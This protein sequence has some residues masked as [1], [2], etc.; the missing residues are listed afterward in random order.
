MVTSSKILTVSYGTF[1]CTLE[2]FDDPFTTLQQVA[3]Y[4]RKLAAADRYFGGTPQTPSTEMLKEIAARNSQ[5]EVDAMT[6]ENGVVLR[7]T[8][9]PA[10][11]KVSEP[12]ADPVAAEKAA[13][14]TMTV[15]KTRQPEVE[16]AETEPQ[17]VVTAPATPVTNVAETLAAIRHNVEQAETEIAGQDR[18]PHETPDLAAEFMAG[19]MPPEENLPDD[20]L[21]EADFADAETD[22]KQAVA[23]QIAE[24]VKDISAAELP[25]L[26]TSGLRVFDITA[27]PADDAAD[28]PAGA[29]ED[30]RDWVY[31]DAG[32]DPM[33]VIDNLSSYAD[34]FTLKE[35]EP[36]TAEAEAETE[37]EAEAEPE[38]E[39]SRDEEPVIVETPVPQSTA[40]TP[41]MDVYKSPLISSLTAE[42]ELELARDLAEAMAANPEP[43]QEFIAASTRREERR[44][45]AAALLHQGE[46]NDAD[47]SV[48]R[49]MATTQSKM[50]RP[51]LIRRIDT[52]GHLKAA[53]AATEAEAEFQNRKSD[54]K[55]KK[56]KSA[57]GLDKF[58]DDYTQVKTPE[59]LARPTGSST[60]RPS[61]TPLILV[62]EQRIDN[63]RGGNLR[64]A[65]FQRASD[66]A[67]V[68]GN[69]A[70]KRQITLREDFDTVEEEIQGIP[71][72]AFNAS[73][74]GEFAERVGA[75]EMHDLLEASAAFTAIVEGQQDFARADVMNKIASLNHGDGYSKEIGLRAFGKLL[76]EG[77][78]M[79]VQDG[80]FRLA[81]SSRYSIAL[82]D[83]D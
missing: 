53:A 16:Q 6:S 10:A 27:D 7:Q 11:P 72:D 78:L 32:N 61:P 8:E 75:F 50:E 1:S 54:A 41:R 81:A 15:F 60:P 46:G 12:V 25:P 38:F 30:A 49:L 51:E 23:D 20:D 18:P 9:K 14:K 31:E 47:E 70:L 2:G 48:D 80:L 59:R 24:A 44:S 37:V 76:S 19:E 17:S 77:K 66:D 69:L 29:S 73:D 57:S 67:D 3:E 40:A 45:R 52:L 35:D 58:R 55:T 33:P 56:S 28:Q 4:F 64:E 83:A 82:R 74:F 21:A 65:A 5:R 22:E 68:S 63:S 79:R 39:A 62:S 34:S 13:P 43:D 36:E 42:Q 71:A 26:D